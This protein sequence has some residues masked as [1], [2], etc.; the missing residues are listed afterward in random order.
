M[1]ARKHKL[2]FDSQSELNARLINWG[3]WL[4]GGHPR[5]TL[6]NAAPRSNNH[7]AIDAEL[8]EFAITTWAMCSDM[9]EMYAFVVKLHFAEG[10]GSEK[11][12]RRDFRAK[13]NNSVSKSKFYLMLAESKRCLA[14]VLP[15]IGT[16][17]NQPLDDWT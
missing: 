13:F 3:R 5:L 17:R 1:P 10:W 9:A 2:E 14:I 12:L 4:Q 11:D 16:Q 6:S 8:V 7:D 15:D